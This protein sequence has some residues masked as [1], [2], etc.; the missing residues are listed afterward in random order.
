LKLWSGSPAAGAS[1]PAEETAMQ[2]KNNV[3][4]LWW[5][6]MLLLAMTALAEVFVAS[7]YLGTQR[8][9]A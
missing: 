8:E 1:Q 6:F 7:R 3:S 2:E 5:W 9:A 4:S